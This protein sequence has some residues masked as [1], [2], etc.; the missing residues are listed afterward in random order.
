MKKILFFF[1]F[2]NLL[3]S[4][5]SDNEEELNLPPSS[6]ELMVSQVTDV[7]AELNWGV[8]EDPEGKTVVYSVSLNGE[9]IAKNLNENSLSLTELVGSTEYKVVVV[10]TDDHNN[11]IEIEKLFT[12]SI[13]NLAPESFEVFID[14][15][16]NKT[17]KVS[18]KESLDPNGDAVTY[19]VYLNGNIIATDLDVLSYLLEGLESTTSYTVK[20]VSKDA[21]L[22]TEVE[23]MFETT[24]NPPADFNIEIDNISE[25]GALVNWDDAVD[26]DGDNVFYDIYVNGEEVATGWT[27]SIYGLT[28]LSSNTE[29]IVKIVARD[30]NGATTIN[31]V[32]FRTASVDSSFVVLSAD[33]YKDQ[34]V[35]YIVVLKLTDSF[36]VSSVTID[37]TT[38]DDFF[39]AAPDVL[40]FGITEEQYNEFSASAE[41]KGSLKYSSGGKEL[42]Y[43]F[44]Y[45]VK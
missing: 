6:F 12:T 11:S 13:T 43:E 18:W 44:T 3:M 8:S 35:G 7:S 36:A 27:N 5:S 22:A 32:T 20:I 2:V 15:I 42:N 45:N 41:N 33:V 16:T 40:N 14:N 21:E 24:G 4:C 39:A 31:T 30:T 26:P 9:M 19:D 23:K 10:A 38:F 34:Y 25:S 17:A 28:S 1:V 29:Y 37:N